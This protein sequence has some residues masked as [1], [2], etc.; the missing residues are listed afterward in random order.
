MPSRTTWT[1][2]AFSAA[3]FGGLWLLGEA[4]VTFLFQEELQAWEAPTPSPVQGAPNMPGN[5]YLIYEIPPGERY[6][7][8]VT[9]HMN[10]LGLRGPE[11]ELPKPPGERR[12][13][14]TGDSSV[15]GFGVADEAVF[16]EVAE[17]LLPDNVDG[18]TAAIPGYSTFQTLNFLRMR[19]L[20]TEPDLLVIANLWS[21]N[22]FHGWVDKEL[23]ATF[24]SYERSWV[25]LGRDLL[26]RSAIFRLLDW[27]LRVEDSVAN[28]HQVVD[29]MTSGGDTE[30]V[31]R[32]AIQDYAENLEE[33]VQIALDRDGEVLFVVL[34]N[35]EDLDPSKEARRMAWTPYRDVMRETAARHGAPVIEVPELFKASGLDKG[36]LFLDEMHP[37]D[38]GHRIIG[39]AL[40]E[41]LLEKDWASGGRVMTGGTGGPV[42]DYSDPFVESQGTGP[43]G[44]ADGVG[45]DPAASQGLGGGSGGDPGGSPGDAPPQPGQG[46]LTGELVFSGYSTGRLK[47]DVY[48]PGSANPQ[49]LGSADLEAPGSFQ[50]D[51]RGA[52]E[53]VVRVYVDEKG[54]G[55]TGDDRKF[56]F[57]DTP[58]ALEEGKRSG[59]VI[60]LDEGEI[61]LEG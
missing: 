9:I 51:T 19:A 40:A 2:L 56:E 4:S 7:Q 47:L 57:A 36:A 20:Q 46:G 28:A 14:T 61:R 58:I 52:T 23:L 26:T 39:E 24:T 11:P 45:P 16:H 17:D 33:M 25:N 38:S 10:S 53:V 50:L 22:N 41:V 30:G 1:R 18:M 12:F 29:W 37:T 34:A 54:D 59:V 43:I 42:P 8:G 55:P 13:L 31:R 6:E 60:D 21:D 5:P 3:T 32:V 44:G 35:N 49:V 48:A 27:Q 15:F